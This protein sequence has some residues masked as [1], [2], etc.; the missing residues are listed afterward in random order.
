MYIYKPD[1]VMDWA[2]SP[3]KNY[4][5]NMRIGLSEHLYE[6]RFATPSDSEYSD[7]A[8]FIED[9]SGLH[10]D[11][12][13]IRGILALYPST[14]I[15]IAMY[16]VGDTDIR[17]D[18]AFAISHFILGCGWP[19]YGDKVEIEEFVAVLQ[20]QAVHLGF[21]VREDES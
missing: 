16:G 13:R 8:E 2:K 14:R 3:D 9:I 6:N 17:G 19:T 20:K 21:K 10:V 15:K 18:L 5:L 11:A 12:E 1:M 4:L 7:A